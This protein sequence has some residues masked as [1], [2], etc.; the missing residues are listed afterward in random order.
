MTFFL[1]AKIHVFFALTSDVNY[2]ASD[3]ALF[4]IYA[5]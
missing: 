2:E 1:V 3:I 5:N 4:N